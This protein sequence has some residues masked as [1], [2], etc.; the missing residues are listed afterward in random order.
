MSADE[1]ED[2][3]RISRSRAEKAIRGAG[4]NPNVSKRSNTGSVSAAGIKNRT[5]D[6][7][8]DFA[9]QDKARARNDPRSRSEEAVRQDERK[10]APVTTDLEQWKSNPGRWDFPGVDTPTQEP[11]ALPKDYKAGGESNTAEVDEETEIATTNERSVADLYAGQDGMRSEDM[12]NVMVNQRRGVAPE[13]F[14][15]DV[16]TPG[17][18]P[19]M[20][21]EPSSQRLPEP[22]HEDL[23]SDE[24]ADE[25]FVASKR[26]RSQGGG[27]G[28]NFPAW[29]VPRG[30]TYLN[31]KVYD[32]GREDLE[33][34]REKVK[35]VSP[36]SDEEL[37]LTRGEYNT[38]QRIVREG[39]QEE[40]DGADEMEANIFG[41]TD[42][43][44]DIAEQ[45]IQGIIN[46]PPR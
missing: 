40:I 4:G 42:K 8:V 14:E 15:R 17:R 36:T 29:T 38:F 34:L 13:D 46:N 31:E 1:L 33:P 10:R 45:A 44:A 3:A 20:G 32:E 7:W 18:D 37:E 19:T 16:P 22:V 28:F 43:Q 24:A 9:D 39:A 6:F 41:D 5:G 23:A 27:M 12:F 11:K 35:D 21:P 2:K 25:A 30:Q 26:D